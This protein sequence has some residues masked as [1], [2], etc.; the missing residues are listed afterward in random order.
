[1]PMHDASSDDCGV[2]G[3]KPLDGSTS[4]LM[5]S[6]PRLVKDELAVGMAMPVG[7]S[8]RFEEAPPAR[9]VRRIKH[10]GFPDEVW[11]FN[12]SGRRRCAARRG[13]HRLPLRTSE[14]GHREI[15]HDNEPNERAG[16]SAMCDRHGNTIP[17]TS[18]QLTTTRS[19]PSL[20][21]STPCS[22]PAATYTG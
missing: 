8:A 19:V 17:A 10:G 21:A 1:M 20:S 5:Q 13:G 2:A 3:R 18:D 14:P 16:Q 12:R 4:Y 9:D 15:Q 6:G 7:A 11:C 22:T